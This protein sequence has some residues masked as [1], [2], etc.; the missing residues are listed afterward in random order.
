MREAIKQ[1]WQK[2]PQCT[3]CKK[4][5]TTTPPLYPIDAMSFE[6]GELWSVDLF[7]FQKKDYLLGIDKASQYIMI[8][9]IKNK[10]T[11]TVTKCLEKFALML[12]L[13]TLLKSDG[14]PVLKVALF[15]SLQRS[16]GSSR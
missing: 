16:T 3:K 15:R 1:E 5:K 7:K 10:K 12:G 4:S 8:E 9:E 13:P 6:I 2:C 11:A 14:G